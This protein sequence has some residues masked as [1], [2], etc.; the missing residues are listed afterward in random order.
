MLRYKLLLLKP[1]EWV[2]LEVLRAKGSFY[3]EI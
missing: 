3:E 1:F 2:K